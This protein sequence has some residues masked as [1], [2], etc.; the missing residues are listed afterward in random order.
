MNA[1]P[2]ASLSESASCALPARRSV[3]ARAPSVL[4]QRT[5]MPCRRATGTSTSRTKPD[6]ASA[7]GPSTVTVVAPLRA[8]AAAGSAAATS[9]QASRRRTP[10][11]SGG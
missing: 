10:S 11:L 4:T 7:A 3:R 5:L 8:L 9:R 1:V 6:A 2:A